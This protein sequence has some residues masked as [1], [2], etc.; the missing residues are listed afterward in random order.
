M[1]ASREYFLRKIVPRSV[2]F[3]N[4]LYAY[5]FAMDPDESLV[6]GASIE[7]A[8]LAERQGAPP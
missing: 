3:G 5:R 8:D 4:V 6:A 2:S 7:D 1:P